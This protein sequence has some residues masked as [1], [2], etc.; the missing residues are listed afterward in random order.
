MIV[1]LDSAPY[2]LYRWPSRSE[3][4]ALKLREG[5][6]IAAKSV[7]ESVDLILRNGGSESPDRWLSLGRN[8]HANFQ[9][10]IDDYYLDYERTK[11]RYFYGNAPVECGIRL[12][13]RER[14]FNALRVYTGRPAGS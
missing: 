4:V 13:P 8:N 10:Y 5:G 7:P 11:K 3:R 9:N 2:S 14:S 1:A 6:L 12:G